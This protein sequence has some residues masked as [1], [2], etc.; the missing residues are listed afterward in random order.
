MLSNVNVT[1]RIAFLMTDAEC[2]GMDAIRFD[3]EFRKGHRHR[4]H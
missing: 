4:C 1:I 2:R 3:P